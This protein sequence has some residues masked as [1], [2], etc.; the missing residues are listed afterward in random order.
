MKTIDSSSQLLF[1]ALLALG[2]RSL[3]GLDA[4]EVLWLDLS[5]SS[6]EVLLRFL[7]LGCLREG[8]ELI[9]P[10]VT[11]EVVRDCSGMR[12]AL[13]LMAAAWV[14][15]PA[16]RSLLGAALL[17]WGS[18]ALRLTTLGLTANFLGEPLAAWGHDAIG[19]AFLLASAGLLSRFSFLPEAE[20]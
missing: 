7:G 1:L 2:L 5:A 9:L 3:G 13:L 16:L 11:L 6:A 14:R 17:A 8:S 20:A 10:R 18:N 12:S 19:G 15:G 4:L